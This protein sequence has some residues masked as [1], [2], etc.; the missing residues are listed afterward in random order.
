MNCRLVS[1]NTSAHSLCRL[2]KI[3][4]T[5][6]EQA[7]GLQILQILCY[8]PASSLSAIKQRW[9]NGPQGTN[10]QKSCKACSVPY[11]VLIAL[12]SMT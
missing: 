2:I 9:L 4:F 6:L 1:F 5:K 10:L 12:L 8:R 7:K 11:G 3:N